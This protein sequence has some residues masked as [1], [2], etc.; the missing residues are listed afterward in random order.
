MHLLHSSTWHPKRFVS[1]PRDV[2]TVRMA[3]VTISLNPVRLRLRLLRCMYRYWTDKIIDSWTPAPNVFCR[4][5]DAY[6][7]R[8]EG[9]NSAQQREL[10]APNRLIVD[11]MRMVCFHQRR[12]VPEKAFMLGTG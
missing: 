6:R 4:W 3:D 9:A 7:L 2:S 12:K 8:I 5:S 1:N 11:H 10:H